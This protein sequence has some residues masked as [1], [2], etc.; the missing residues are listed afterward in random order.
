MIKRL[1]YY[2]THWEVW[3]WFAKY[4]IIGPAWLWHCL[5]SGSLWFFTPSNPSITFGGFIGESKREIYRQLPPLSYPESIYVSPNTSFS[6]VKDLVGSSGLQ[7]PVA[8]KPDVG[9][10]GFMFRQVNSFRQLREYHA[11]MS[12]DYIIQELVT[13][14]MEVSVFYYRYPGEKKGHITG[15]LKKE[16]MEVT[17][18]GNSTL[19]QLILDYPRAQFRRDELL[20]KHESRLDDVIPNG[21]KYCLSHALNLSRGGRLISLAHEKDDHLLNVFDQLSHY[22]QNF[23]Y[24]RYDFK[25]T[26]IE[27]LKKGKNYS[28]L[29]Y[30]GSGAE[31]HHVYGN[32]HTFFQACRILI[33]HWNVLYRISCLNYR[34]GV[35]RWNFWEG[36]SFAKRAKEHFRKLS[37]LDKQFEFEKKVAADQLALSDRYSTVF[38]PRPLVPQKNLA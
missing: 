4:I 5:R 8:V 2:I 9:M 1:R 25:C 32:A 11:A 16:F 12:V 7:F 14:P 15:F 17:G 23:Y 20:S 21:E 27:D 19:K 28:I 10:M 22:T 33:E 38:V 35:R 6:D 3:H 36:V 31:P 24:G 18:N 13:Y 30:N 37:V 26:S 29:E 34:Q